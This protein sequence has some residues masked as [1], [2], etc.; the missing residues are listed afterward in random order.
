[1]DL[2]RS[3]FSKSM[4]NM[5]RDRMCELATHLL[6]QQ[7]FYP[8]FPVPQKSNL[9]LDDTSKALSLDFIPDLLILPS[10]LTGFAKVLPRSDCICV[11]PGFI[12][13][14][15]SA[16]TYSKISVHKGTG[17]FCYRSRAEIIRL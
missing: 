6:Q 1:M 3:E 8:L 16:G 9:N 4:G 12:T 17:P 10:A 11:N 5:P 7:C 2:S 15:D 14:G 13:K